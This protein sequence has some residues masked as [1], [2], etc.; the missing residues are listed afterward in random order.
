MSK[1][2]LRVV[3]LVCV[4]LG[5]FAFQASAQDATIVGTVTDPSGAVVPNV[6]VTVTSAATNQV[7]RVTTNEGGQ[8]LIPNL[9]IGHYNVQAEA[10]GFKKAEQKDVVVAVGDR[11]RIDFSLEVGSAQ[12][13]V[14][15]E[16]TPIA[17]QAESGEVSGV[18]T[19]QQVSQL[20]TNGRSLYSLAA[21]TP[22]ASSNMSDYQSATPVGGSAQ[23]SFNGLRREHNIYLIDGGENLDRGGAGTIS[24]MPSMDAIAEFRQLTSNYGSEFGLSSG[25]TMT[26]VL[27]SGTRGLHASGWEFLRNEDFDANTFFRNKAGQPNPVNRMN[28][29]GFNVGGPVFIPKVYN[30]DRQK[31]FFFYNMEWRKLVQG[32]NLNTT[33][34]LSSTYGGNFG[35]SAIFV[36]T[37]DKLSAAQ[38]A[39]FAAAG[40]NPGQQFP[41]NTIPTSLLDPNAQAL[42][43]AG[44]FPAPTQ[45]N[46]YV[47]G[48]N[49]PTNVREELVRIDHH[50]TDKFWV[51]GHFIDESILQ[52]Y[53]TTMW[54]GDNVPSAANTFGNPSYSGVVHTVYSISPSILNEVAFNYNGNR[55]N[56]L[57][58]AGSVIGR[59]SDFKVPELF[60]ANSLNRFPSIQLS[61][62]T[63]TNYD[64]NRVPWV[65]KADDYQIRDDISWTK[66]SHQ[67]K[68]GASWALYKKVQDVFGQTQ[69]SFQF[70]GNYTGNDFA[71]FLLGYSN[72]YQ[73]AAI[74]DSGH[75]DNQSWAIYAQDN[76]KVNRQLTL[77]LGVRWDA[78]PHTYEEN[79]RQSNFYP[80][81]YDPAKKAILVGGNT[82]SPSSPGL[83]T[84]PNPDLAGVKF[85]LNGIGIAGQNG[86]SRGL[87]NNSWANI[88]PRVGFAYDL[89]G[90][91]DTVIRGGF[92][93]MYERVQ[94]NDV[95]NGGSNVPFSTQVTFQNILLS[96]PN[97]SILTGL[98]Q[99]APITVGDI[100]GLTRSNYKPPVSYQ[101]SIGFQRQISR[102]SVLSVAYV[103]N[104]NR[105]Q[106]YYRETN[107]P[108]QSVLPGLIQG[109]VTK[110]SVVPYVGFGSIR[111]SENANN[112][113]YNGLQVGYRGQFGKPLTI[114]LSY[115]F[116][117]AIDPVAQGGDS[118]DMQNITNP[119][120]RN[121][122]IGP[123]PL[124]RRHIALANFIYQIPLFQGQYSRFVKATLGGWEL[125]GIG[126]METGMPL[127]MTVSGSQGNNGLPNTGNRPNYS[128]SIGL[129]H[130]LDQWFATSAFSLPALGAWG[131]LPKGSIYGPGRHN[132]NLALFKSFAFTETLR[133]E[134]RAET[135]NTFNHTQYN[136]ISTAYGA[137][138]FGQVT[139]TYNPRN[140]QLGL[141]LLF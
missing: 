5:A 107:L 49:A 60:P 87:V 81:L 122:D 72:Q 124:D 100:T 113:H 41:N 54:S 112:S 69:G 80:E 6:T 132:W 19:G 23:V 62:A 79:D 84:S 118:Q 29:Y 115:T 74:Q 38:V 106:N 52:T 96:N 98:T 51:F 76:W 43:K 135:F 28:V 11:A 63:G 77:T 40:L 102:D 88:G 68:V 2:S 108:D 70:N 94:G 58:L 26:M 91:G 90:S 21:L 46:K 130:T 48:N 97:T 85:Y 15:V 17:V 105:H 66:G 120:N 126:T 44:I 133:A 53:G 67:F 82:I 50:F 75:W 119:Y 24:V 18:I 37:A 140:I 125:S 110:N 92:G 93:I 121:Y 59:T 117:K 89:T 16:A 134:F 71:D 128:G 31:T 10:S 27:K 136:G 78:I 99:T 103:G 3:L 127:N 47:G 101:W 7:R 86:I 12:E 13:S 56:I 55:I 64:L 116:S 123:S 139:S 36:P 1:V 33:V 34:P 8:Y 30:K 83:G 4:L 22:G 57:P 73:E 20:A 45:G 109:T 114:Q 25:G 61:G 104:Q 9:Q 141:K 138:D 42:L 131:N 32:G 65:N 95:Y 39:R 35:S 14:T 137:S 111:M 129:P